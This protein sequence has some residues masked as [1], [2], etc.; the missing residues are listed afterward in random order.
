M[1]GWP[2]EELGGKTTLEAASTPVM[3]RLAADAEIGTASMVPEE[4]APGSDTANLSVMGYDPKIYYTGRSPL[5]ALSIGVDMADDDVSFR[6]NLVTLSGE[7]A[8]YGD[9]HMVDHSS[10][11]IS[12]EDA[13]VLLE[14]LRQG[15]GREGYT[16]YRGT[17]Y[18]HLLVWSKGQVMELTPPHD[19]LT[20]RIGDY[21]P[22]DPVLREMMEKSYEILSSHPLNVEREK[23]GLHPANSAW[24]WGAGTR[25]AL[26]SFEG[27]TGKRG[28]MISAVYLL[29]GLAVG[30][31]MDRVLVEGANG[32]LDT[33]YEGKADAAVKA[34][35][36]DG[37]DFA[38][39]HVEAPDEMGHQ[40]SVRDKIKAIEYLDA[41]VIGRITGRLDAAGEDYRIMV[42]PDHPTPIRVRTHTKDPVPYM[43]YDSRRLLGN[44]GHTYGES[45]ARRSG[46]VWPKGF[47]LI[48]HLL[49]L[50]ER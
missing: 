10:S 9:R 46:L 42:L 15:L 22:Q 43:I 49:E 35:L 32:G 40:G 12:T 28:V 24:F 38:Y 37:Y 41:R 8:S 20:K 25:P 47:R 29:K 7:E 21:L 33:N 14:A 11:E 18:R 3:D 44:S 19:I 4:M 6:C 1:A 23:R 48:D 50:D 30:A 34:L 13:G 5:E 16:F 36:E 45:A 26:T 2:L 27:K 31:Q 17:S 39:V